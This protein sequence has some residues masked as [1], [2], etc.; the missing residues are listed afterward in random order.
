MLFHAGSQIID[1]HSVD[2]RHAFVVLHSRQRLVQVLALDCHR[3][4]GDR[5]VF[6]TG[7]RR[8][9]FSL[10]RAQGFTLCSGARVQLD[11]ILLRHGSCVIAALLGL[12]H[13][14]PS[15]VRQIPS[16]PRKAIQLQRDSAELYLCLPRR[17]RRD[18]PG[19]FITR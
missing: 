16:P 10:Q 12:F 6:T 1:A 7:F 18:K 9:N 14:G 17:S 5:R 2:V 11:L 19:D 8:A 15:A 4:P 13:F 3:W